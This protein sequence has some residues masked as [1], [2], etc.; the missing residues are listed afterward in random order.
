M[1]KELRK[2]RV[3]D[4]PPEAVWVALTDP[5]ALAEWL[6]P[7]T[8]KA[9]VGCKFEFMTDPHWACGAH[10]TECE[11][12]ELEPNRRMV[13]S[14][15]MTDKKKG[16]TYPPLHITWELSP[17]GSGTR[18][19]FTQTGMEGHKRSQMFMMNMGWGYMVKKLIPRLLPNCG[20]D[21]SFTP[22]AIPLAKRC[23][24]VKTV[25]AEFVR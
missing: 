5:R 3:Y 19:R 4:H 10:R 7:N 2:E 8:F 25:P 1:A 13:W 23:Y 21:G 15:T 6:M 22:G 12:L 20:A 11:V 9:E 17:E 24:K 14:W 16:K 18:L